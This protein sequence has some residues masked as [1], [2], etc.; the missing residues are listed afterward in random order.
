MP[1][2]SRALAIEALLTGA[3][4]AVKACSG[5][6]S[7]L[8]LISSFRGARDFFKELYGTKLLLVEGWER[9]EDS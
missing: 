5:H 6:F 4:S 8:C 7:P 9:V 2:L 1:D 3:F